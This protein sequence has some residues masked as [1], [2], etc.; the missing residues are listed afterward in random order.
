M[1]KRSATAHAL[2]FVQ[3]CEDRFFR[4]YSPRKAPNDSLYPASALQEMLS[5]AEA[6]QGWQERISG[7]LP[8][9]EGC[10]PLMVA[11]AVPP[12]GAPHTAH[13]ANLHPGKTSQQTKHLSHGLTQAG[14]CTSDDLW[15]G[16]QP[17]EDGLGGGLGGC[18]SLDESAVASS[19]GSPSL[20]RWPFT[21][22]WIL[23]IVTTHCS[24]LAPVAIEPY[25][26]AK[27]GPR[28]MILGRASYSW[29]QAI[30][31]RYWY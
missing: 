23:A 26:M 24:H 17:A 14:R 16:G 3:R 27:V 21:G 8:L 28:V 9:E 6:K 2:A 18:I 11:R 29:N 30:I 7:D 12:S 25:L 20:S 19:V 10:R 4:D 22:C 5:H 31:L 13:V 15:P 1:A